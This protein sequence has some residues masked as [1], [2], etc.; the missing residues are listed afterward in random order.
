M[1]VKNACATDS[2]VYGCAKGTKWQYL[3]KRSMMERMTVLPCTRGS[4]STKSRP[5]STKTMDGTG[6]GYSKP[7][8]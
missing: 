3:L 8:G 7:A 2:T 5:M 1:S 6:R 4:A